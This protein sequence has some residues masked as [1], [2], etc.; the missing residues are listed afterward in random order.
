[1]E[2]EQESLGLNETEQDKRIFRGANTMIILI[3]GGSH[4]GKTV[5]AQN[6]MEKYRY[7]YM[8]VD[9]IKMGLIRSGICILTPESSHEELT[10]FFWPV[11][12]EIIKT[13]IENNQNLIIEGCYI[14]FDYKK[15]FEL[16][17]LEQIRYTC[18]IFSENYIDQYFQ[19][20]LQYAN[21]I[22]KR[23]F[24]DCSKE[25]LIKENKNNLNS[26]IAHECDYILIDE[27]YEIDLDII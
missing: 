21:V 2:S 13:N 11:I 14:P 8:S 16:N 18:L 19:D 9:H 15:E 10:S 22:E 6:L 12:R 26:C 1:V 4:T 7:P 20:I 3:T 17:Y 24:D 25:G 5:L 23:L 27:E